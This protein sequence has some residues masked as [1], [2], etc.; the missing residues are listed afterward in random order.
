[1]PP[2]VI[3]WRADAAEESGSV[4]ASLRERFERDDPGVRSAMSD[5]AGL[6]RRARDALIAGDPV[7][8]ARCVD[9]SFDARAQ[10]MTL[11]PRHVSMIERARDCGASANY[12]GSG[13]A[14]VAVCRD[15]SHQHDV[16][17]YLR[18]AGCGTVSPSP[19]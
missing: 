2:L 8:F 15:E 17:Q 12:A 18:A 1:M 13:G 6:A 9:G 5:L 19:A 16:A 11:D 4:H 3:A 10:M 14:I 7:Q